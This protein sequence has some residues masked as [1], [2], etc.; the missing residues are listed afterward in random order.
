MVDENSH[1]KRQEK[2]HTFISNELNLFGFFFLFMFYFSFAYTSLSMT[3]GYD[4]IKPSRN[5]RANVA[6]KI[7]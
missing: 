5:A 4:I 1:L 2:K 6:L 7:T 3:A